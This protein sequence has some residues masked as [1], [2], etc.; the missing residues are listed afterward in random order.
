MR[1]ILRFLTVLCVAA[2]GTTALAQRVGQTAPEIEALN[3]LNATDSVSLAKYKGKIVVLFFWRTT[4]GESVDA[5]SGLNEIHDKLG[6]RGVV[7]IAHSAE[8]KEKVES[9]VSGKSVKFIVIYG[10]DMHTRYKVTSFPRVFLIDT[11]GTIVWRGHPA[12]ELEERVKEQMRKTPPAGT[13]EETL[14]GQARAAK[15]DYDAGEY[16]KAYTQAKGVSN[17]VDANSD[18]GKAVKKLLDDIEAGARKWLEEAKQAARGGRYEEACR[19]LAQISVR[20]AGSS[21]GN[22][23]DDECAR[24]RADNK[25]KAVV[26]KAISNAKGELRN[27]EIARLMETKQYLKALAACREVVDEYSG[28]AAAEVAQAEIERINNDPAIQASLATARAEEQ[29]SRWLE[30]GD[31]FA[32]VEMYDLARTQYE[33]VVKGHPKSRAAAKATDRMKGLPRQ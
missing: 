28:T 27:E 16:G 17:V 29:A 18:L 19:K 24:L 11:H 23:A 26:I 6:Q 33:K 8:A 5:L 25:S 3:Q 20:F 10:N 9:V 31:R 13:D 30:L 32:R 21:L 2:M 12:D 14:R 22:D 4:D 1:A 15:A 7:I